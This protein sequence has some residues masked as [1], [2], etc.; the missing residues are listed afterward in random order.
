MPQ[1]CFYLLTAASNTMAGNA[2]RLCCELAA[3]A[4]QQGQGMVIY[5]QDRAQA[6]RLDE[7][8][9]QF[10]AE[11]FIPHNLA[12]EGPAGGAP[13]VIHWLQR[14]PPLLEKRQQ[15]VNLAFELP[16]FAVQ[17]AQ[18]FDFVAVE[19]HAKAQA[20]RRFSAARQMGLAPSTHNL[21]LQPL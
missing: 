1:A 2:E 10:D 17:F 5:C 6:E 13:V 8:L 21:A 9:W 12:G 4:Y 16:S 11:R 18:I 14:D 3:R 15:L 20:R 7:L 19:E